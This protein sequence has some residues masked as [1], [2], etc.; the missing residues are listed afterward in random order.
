MD[1]KSYRECL[2]EGCLEMKDFLIRIEEVSDPNE[3]QKQAKAEYTKWD[4]LLCGIYHRPSGVHYEEPCGLGEY[5]ELLNQLK[6]L[7]EKEKVKNTNKKT[8]RTCLYCKQK[9]LNSYFG[10]NYC[11][12]KCALQG[13]V[14]NF[15]QLLSQQINS[16]TSHLQ[17]Y[18]E[19]L[20]KYLEEFKKVPH[21]Y[22]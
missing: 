14:S 3:K 2:R 11:D 4:M 22:L 8:S 6:R 19:K 9:I 10:Q 7:S 17:P 5:E 16:L 21:S 15:A 13:E 18:A 1:A 12:A 20:K